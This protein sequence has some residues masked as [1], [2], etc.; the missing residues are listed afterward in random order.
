MPVLS[1]WLLRGCSRARTPHPVLVKN[2]PPSAGSRAVRPRTAPPRPA[3]TA[4]GSLDLWSRPS[5]RELGGLLEC[6]IPMSSRSVKPAGSRH[7]CSHILIAALIGHVRYLPRTR[8]AAGC[9][10]IRRRSWC[11]ERA[12]RRV[13]WHLTSRPRPQADTRSATA[14]P[15][16]GGTAIWRA[17]PPCGRCGARRPRTAFAAALNDPR[18]ADKRRRSAENHE[19]P[20][21]RTS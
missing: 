11:R 9:I 12:E 10:V 15:G 3:N 4:P 21:S 6:P 19:R 8:V 20:L 13:R 7:L 1:L 16:T 2:G 18:P 17:A 14:G 5:W